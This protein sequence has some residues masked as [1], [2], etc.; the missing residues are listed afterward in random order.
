[1]Q[2]KHVTPYMHCMVYH[3]PRMLRLYGNIKQFSG[4]GESVSHIHTWSIPFLVTSCRCWEKKDDS[5]RHYYSSNK[6]DAPAEIIRSD[7]RLE[8][9]QQ[10]T[11]GYPSCERKK[12]KY[13]KT[14]W[15]I[16]EW[17][18]DPEKPKGK[19]TAHMQ[20][21]YQECNT[22]FL[23]ATV[24]LKDTAFLKATTFQKSSL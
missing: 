17:W 16:L 7:A 15:G 19:A 8:M 12:R 21:E 1:M 2:G 10:G 23:K 3:I 24:F 14:W 6:H 4:Q 13:D 22:A 20:I 11:G 9:L 18:R 5:K